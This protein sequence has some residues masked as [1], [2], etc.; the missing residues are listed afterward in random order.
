MNSIR[1]QNVKLSLEG[2]T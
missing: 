1:V 2:W